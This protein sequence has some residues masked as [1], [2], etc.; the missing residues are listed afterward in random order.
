MD[1]F[2]VG[3]IVNFLKYTEKLRVKLH[4]RCFRI[5]EL[6]CCASLCSYYFMEVKIFK[7]LILLSLILFGDIYSFPVDNLAMNKIQLI[8]GINW[9]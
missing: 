8:F 7:L 6:V 5:L 4:I 3:K 9:I 2:G 1:L